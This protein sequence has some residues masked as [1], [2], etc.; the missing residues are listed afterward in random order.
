MLI[1][2]GKND[3]FLLEK[4]KINIISI[5]VVKQRPIMIKLPDTRGGRPSV[6]VV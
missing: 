2:C 5:F 6:S 4:P 3:S 1:K